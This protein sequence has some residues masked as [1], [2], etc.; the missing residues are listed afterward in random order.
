MSDVEFI[1]DCDVLCYYMLFLFSDL[2]FFKFV[3][4]CFLN[5]SIMI[6]CCFYVFF[7]FFELFKFFY[8]IVF[9]VNVIMVIVCFRGG[10]LYVF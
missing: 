9:Y 7:N 5:L 3:N 8:I 2:K 6:N 1:L 4:N 10:F